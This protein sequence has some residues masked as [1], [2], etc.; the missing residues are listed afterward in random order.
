MPADT[1]TLPDLAALLG[2]ATADGDLFL[3]HHAGVDY[4]VTKLQLMLAVGIAGLTASRVLLSDAD[5]KVSASSI[6]TTI[7]GYIANLSSDA[8]TQINGKAA[9]SHTHDAAAITT[10]TLDPARI[11]V[12][13][14]GVQVISTGG[15]ANL[16]AGQQTA[17][18]AGAIVTTTDGQ[19]WVYKGTGS[20]TLEASYILCADV[21]PDWSV[22]ANKPTLGTAAALD[23]GTTA[24][25]V[26]RLDADAKLP[27]VDGSQ[28]TNLPGGGGDVAWDDIEDKP[29]FGTAALLDVGVDADNVLQLNGTAKIPAGLGV[30]MVAENLND[31]ASI[32]TARTNIGLGT[33][34]DVTFGSITADGSALTGV[35]H[36]S[37]NLADLGNIPT[38]RGILGLGSA[39]LLGASEVFLKADNLSGIAAP[40]TARANLGLAAVAS[41]G[42]YSDLTGKP[43]IPTVVSALTNDSGYLVGSA[44]FNGSGAYTNFTIV[45]GQ[46]TGAS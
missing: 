20:K 32:A 40:I 39:A 46:I 12:L 37:S 29:A 9:S 6:S 42:D 35:M 25:K 26:V 3:I 27:A 10:G 7:L 5:G 16:D 34:S 33:A 44:G 13:F 23:V 43:S 18:T 38:A 17:V 28:L 36:P 22:V 24:L 11:G 14:S 4:K 15:I 45:N 30:L 2:A 21:T 8:Q 41:T 1:K 31:L 19:R